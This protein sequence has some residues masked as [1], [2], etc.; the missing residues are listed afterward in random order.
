MDLPVQ[1]K[2]KHKAVTNATTEMTGAVRGSRGHR[3]KEPD[4]LKLGEGLPCWSSG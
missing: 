4:P 3:K 1:G 2:Y